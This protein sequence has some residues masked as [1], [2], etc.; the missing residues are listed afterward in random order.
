MKP[1]VELSPGYT[2][3]DAHGYRH[4]VGPCA[5]ADCYAI[6]KRHPERGNLTP[7]AVRIHDGG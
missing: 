6:H 7:A 5:C 2:D 4:G 1:P 3:H